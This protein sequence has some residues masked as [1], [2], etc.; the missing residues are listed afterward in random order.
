MKKIGLT[1]LCLAVVSLSL[2][3]AGVASATCLDNCST[4]YDTCLNGCRSITDTSKADSCVRGCMRGY[5]G[6]KARCG[7]SSEYTPTDKVF[8]CGVVSGDMRSPQATGTCDCSKCR[9]NQY[10]CPTANG[11]CGCFPM[12]CP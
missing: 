10:C 3:P 4:Q 9:S 12:P 8:A 1:V 5:E 2:L 6:C 7:S 11:Y